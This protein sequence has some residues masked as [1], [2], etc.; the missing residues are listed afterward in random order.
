[1]DFVAGKLLVN[2]VHASGLKIAD[3]LSKSSDP[4]VTCVLPNVA[5]KSTKIIHSCLNP[6]F[7]EQLVFDD[8]KVEKTKF[9]SNKMKV[10]IKDHDVG[11]QKEDLL[12]FVD[13]DLT[14]CLE[15]P[16]SWAINEIF[17]VHGTTDI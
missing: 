1:M 6:I 13:V 5:E 10:V 17:K 7:N 15:K 16:G 2:V 3:S 9:L 14:V 12:G 11:P 8:F 4:Y